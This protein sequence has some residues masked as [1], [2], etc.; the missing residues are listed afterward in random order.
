[1]DGPLAAIRAELRA[2]A[3][4]LK[5]EMLRKFFKTG[6]GEYGED[7]RFLGIVVPALRAIAR[8]HLDLPR[9][10]IEALLASEFHEE[11]LGALII[12][13]ERFA[14]APEDE[15]A[16]IYACYVRNLAHVDNW[17]LVDLTAPHIVGRWLAD[18][19]RAPLYEWARSPNLWKRRIAIVATHHFIRNGQF[20]DTCA[21]AKLLLVDEE[22]L[23]HK[24]VGWMLRE[25]GTH[26]LAAEVEFLAQH[27]HTM[28]RTMLRYA[29][30][31]FPE[32]TRQTYLRGTA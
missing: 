7:D 5:A 32:A 21:I 24:A 1:M 19:D 22:D 3:D 26:D 20:A 15:R 18:K 2:R 16:R 12:L 6:P 23:I 11:R 13:V 9:G 17:D 28:P 10:A 29:I 27:Y 8:A 30:E 4:P 31:R 14:R 25:V